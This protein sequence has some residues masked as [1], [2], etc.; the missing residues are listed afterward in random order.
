MASGLFLCCLHPTPFRQGLG[1]QMARGRCCERNTDPF[2]AATSLA[3]FPPLPLATVP[4]GPVRNEE[5][6]LEGHGSAVG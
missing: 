1:H 6:V 2:A 4:P 3:P 5:Q